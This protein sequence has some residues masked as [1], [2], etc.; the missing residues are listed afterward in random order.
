VIGVKKQQIQM[1]PKI[2]IIGAKIFFILQYTN[3]NQKTEGFLKH[4]QSECKIESEGLSI[5]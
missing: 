4:E 5:K 3:W 1:I 2:N